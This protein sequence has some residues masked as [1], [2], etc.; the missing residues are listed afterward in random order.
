MKP[1]TLG[2]RI[3]YARVWQGRQSLSAFG[4]AVAHAQGRRAPYSAAAVS[5]WERDQRVPRM[6][7]LMATARATGVRSEWLLLGAGNPEQ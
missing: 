7:T 6:A 2:Q 5:L 4:A 3:Y 1:R